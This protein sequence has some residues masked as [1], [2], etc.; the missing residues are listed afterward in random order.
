MVLLCLTVSVRGA[1]P[2]T[3]PKGRLW[4]VVTRK[5]FLDDLK[6]LIEH[7]RG[8]GFDVAVSTL[9]PAKA[10]AAQ[11][12]RPAFILL[13]GDDQPGKQAENW[14]L[15]SPRRD[16]YRWRRDQEK[17]FAADMLLGD[18]DSDL[19][20]DAPVGRLAVRTAEQ[21]K[22]QVAQIIAHESREPSLDDL[23]LPVWGGAP[24]YN[25]FVDS[26]STSIALT[27]VTTNSPRWI[28]TWMILADPK[29]P[30]CGTPT[31]QAA[32]F[33][34]Q[35]S[36]GGAMGV[37]IGH[38]SRTSFFSMKSGRG[39]IWFTAREARKGLSKAAPAPPMT[40]LSCYTG[41]FTDQRESLAESLLTIPGGP[42]AVIAA[43]TQSHPLTNFYSGKCLL[44]S[45]GR[46][47]NRLGD[48]W[49]DTQKRAKDARSP[50]VEKILLDIEGKLEDQM[51]AT[52][53]RRDQMLMYAILGDP[54]TRLH[55][56]QRLRGKIK[57]VDGK[58]NWQVTKPEGTTVL[59]VAFRASGQRFPQLN[60]DD[61]NVDLDKLFAQADETFAFK[62]L[63]KLGDN[64]KWAG[65]MSG[66]GTLRLVAIGP[67]KIYAAGINLVTPSDS[68]APVEKPKQ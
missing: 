54:A 13:V 9:A 42:V 1:E 20:P 43:T 61:K 32:M 6:P 31:K 14:Y 53:L 67:G 22:T 18:F 3:S 35:L 16:L 36:R 7:R 48:L 19:I 10:I 12:K 40:I 63:K 38:G 47:H 45:F 44:Q 51:N 60:T 11:K 58:W 66:E 2:S 23:R 50:M 34:G 27:A 49:L 39:G 68:P 41:S 65:A 55:L 15:P 21:L 25:A 28:R 57:F 52:K 33:T 30:L 24:G 46:G 64:D 37:L 62:P 5:M 56:P 29:H 26:M 4:L 8:E 59:H 17:Q